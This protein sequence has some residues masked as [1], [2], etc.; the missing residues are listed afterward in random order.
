MGQRTLTPSASAISGYRSGSAHISALFP[1][2]AF[3]NTTAL[4]SRWTGS[5][6]KGSAKKIPLRS[7]DLNPTAAE[8]SKS[9]K[10]V[11]ILLNA[12]SKIAS[13]LGV[14]WKNV[15]QQDDRHI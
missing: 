14:H 6:S 5:C 2:D 9:G 4:M 1:A 10:A 7:S 8:D 11:A 15:I 12:G 13:S 3:F